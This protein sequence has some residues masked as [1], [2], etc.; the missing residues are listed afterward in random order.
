MKK[1]VIALQYFIIFD[2]L[3]SSMLTRRIC[4]MYKVMLLDDEPW[5]LRGLKN[6]LPWNEYGFE[7]AAERS[8]PLQ[9]LEDL[10]QNHFD[11]LVS[12]IRMP[13]LDG[14]SLMKKIRRFNSELE[15]IFISG[16]AE[17]EYAREAL[18]AG[19]YDYLLK[20][21]DL[22]LSDALLGQLKKRID[23]TH[24]TKLLSLMDQ[25]IN[26]KLKFD[27]LFP[28]INRDVT[29]Q[30]VMGG[31]CLSSC[32]GQAEGV[33]SFCI[34][35]GPDCLLCF[36]AY[37]EDFNPEMYLRA[38][39]PDCQIGLS[40]PLSGDE[41]LLPN[42]L[43]RLMSQSF[44]AYHSSFFQ[45]E[46]G[47][48]SYHETDRNALYDIAEQFRSLYTSAAKEE[49][50]RFLRDLPDILRSRPV[51]VTSI[52]RLWNQLM[53]LILADSDLY[54]ESCLLSA[55]HMLENY[56][57]A[58]QLCRKLEL[59]LEG[60]SPSGADQPNTKGQDIYAAMIAFVNEHF[61][62]PI[63]LQDVADCVHI[64]F[65]YASR[66]FKK[67]TDTNYSKYL[68]RLRMELACRLLSDTG[69]STEE[70]CYEIG[71]H[72]YFY[73]N[74]TFKKYTGQTPLQYRSR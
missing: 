56:S 39:L 32:F 7:V 46:P 2:I 22:D 74:R 64:N 59:L 10:K 28:G 27:A 1:I 47:L 37:K 45:T 43:N 67:Y 21:V 57:N 69:K 3:N 5:E 53:L 29:C 8:N 11:V 58:E 19:A 30:A 16:H 23:E 60:S 12:D 31:T 73:F 70:I 40:L 13:G 18:R 25:I 26:G 51:N 52:V 62:E 38:R 34:P 9:A 4:L 35:Y 36:F 6:M 17:F 14:I 50:Q 71:Y 42:S 55:E 48:Y 54:E 33:S 65:T 66:L 72:D 20:P 63:T 15:I 24:Q 41:V 44:A 61:K 49:L 68:T